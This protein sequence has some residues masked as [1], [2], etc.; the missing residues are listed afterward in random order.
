MRVEL[1]KIQAIDP[2][3]IQLLLAESMIIK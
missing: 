3:G 2:Y 1:F